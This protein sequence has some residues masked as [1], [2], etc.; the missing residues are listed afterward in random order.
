MK[1]LSIKNPWAY[2][3]AH[4]YK[5]VENRKWKTL[6]RGTFL[7]HASRGMTQD[8]TIDCWDT[9]RSIPG[10]RDRIIQRDGADTMTWR[11]LKDN[12]SGGI[13]GVADL[14]DVVHE[15]ERHRLPDLAKPWFFG[16]YGFILENARPLPFTPYKGQLGFFDIPY[17]LENERLL[18]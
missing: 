14:V 5:P 8:E 16:P 13:I 4:G 12:F 2:F 6:F 11:N 18:P 1:A 15:S 9:V 17:D 7:I 10:M 3:C